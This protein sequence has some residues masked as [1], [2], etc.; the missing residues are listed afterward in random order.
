MPTFM[1][2]AAGAK[3]D[4]MTGADPNKLKAMVEA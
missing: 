2:F 3:V 1:A 4:E